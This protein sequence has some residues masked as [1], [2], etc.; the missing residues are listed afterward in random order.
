[1]P[2]NHCPHQLRPLHLLLHRHRLP[3]SASLRVSLVE[4][5]PIA[6]SSRFDLGCVATTHL[7]CC[8]LRVNTGNLVFFRSAVAAWWCGVYST[9]NQPVQ[10]AIAGLPES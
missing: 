6:A 2:S 1:M 8:Q 7:P 10:F 5:T 3:E 9:V 4:A